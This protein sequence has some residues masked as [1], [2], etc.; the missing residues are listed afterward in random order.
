MSNIQII[1]QRKVAELYPHPKNESIYGDENIQEIAQSIKEDGLTKPLIIKPDGR[2]ISGHRRWK[3]VKLLGWETVNVIEQEF[4]DDAEELKTLLIENQ[5]RPAKTN[6]QKCREGMLWEDI[7]QANS[8]K[9]MGLKGK[10]EGL[11]RDRIAKKVGFTSGVNYNKARLVVFAIDETEK[12]SNFAKA[13]KLRKALNEK[14]VNAAYTI[15]NSKKN[16]TEIQHTHIQWILAKLGQTLCDSVWIAHGDHSKIW[17]NDKLGGFSIDTLPNLGINDPAQKTVEYIDTVWFIGQKEVAAAFEVECTTSIYSGLLRLADLVALSPNLSFPVYII[18]PQSR[19]KQVKKELSRA[20]FKTLKLDKIC[21]WIF[22][23]D[24]L[25]AWEAIME[26]GT[27]E[28][29]RKIS[30]TIDSFKLDND[31]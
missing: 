10:G 17:Q 27:V 20:C 8:R 30:Y 23:E 4:T 25:K 15:L 12:S 6:E 24:L 19:A 14:S 1:K 29:I 5:Y 9:L 31:D 28:S 21:R 13:E 3:A 7:E 2:I 16:G 26:Y 18:L 22:I 11:S